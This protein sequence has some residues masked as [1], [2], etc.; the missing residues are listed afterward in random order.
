MGY[1]MK[2]SSYADRGTV[3][4]KLSAS[5]VIAN[6]EKGIYDNADFG[7]DVII[8]TRFVKY[9]VGSSYIT[10]FSPKTHTIKNAYVPDDFECILLRGKAKDAALEL[11]NTYAM[12]NLRHAIPYGKPM[13]GSDPEIFAQDKEGRV[14][15]AFKFLGSKTSP[16]LSKTNLIHIVGEH[17]NAC[18]WDGFQA[19]FDTKEQSCLGWHVDSVQNGLQGI[20]DALN[21]YDKDAVL[22]FKTTMPIPEEMLK[23]AKDEHVQFGCMPS[24]NAYGMDGIKEDG[25]KVPFRSAGGHIHFGLTGGAPKKD[26]AN[27]IVKAL[28][29]ILGVACV[30]L[31]EGFDDPRR[32]SMY[33]L[34]G[35]YR[36]PK[37]GLEYRTLSNAWLMHPL[38]MNIV[39]DLSRAALKIGE[40][41][42]LHLWNASEADT[43]RI[44][45]T[46]NVNDARKVLAQ[47]KT[48]FEQVIAFGYMAECN[49]LRVQAAIKMFTEGMSKHI[50]DPKNIAKNWNLDGRWKNHSDGDGKRMANSSGLIVNHK[51]KVA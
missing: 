14:I 1:K 30:S 19:E 32:R 6:A 8:M 15:P 5:K 48:M 33:G 3:A 49:D 50:V 47:N 39:F 7:T 43:I 23:E 31:F 27:R 45:N 12:K 41:N 51:M 2:I 9:G 37:H 38:L 17:R 4:L 29:T 22:S 18:Y 21:A 13:V 16:T 28:D 10:Y 46:C 26:A 11:Y 40:S 25:R 34:A 24:L 35:E 36:L 20:Y 42:M 44:I